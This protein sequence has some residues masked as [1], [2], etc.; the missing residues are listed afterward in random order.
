MP[1]T[2]MPPILAQGTNQALLYTMV[3]CKAL[4]ITGRDPTAAKV[5]SR[6]RWLVREDQAAQAHRRV[7]VTSRP[8]VPE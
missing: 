1:H 8:D 4:S 5:T 7:W 2:P 3:L 6:A